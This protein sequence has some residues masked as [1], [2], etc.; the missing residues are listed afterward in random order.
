MVE[1]FDAPITKGVCFLHLPKRRT[2]LIQIIGR[3]LRLHKTKTIANMILPYSI[4]E[5]E[6]SI[7]YLSKFSKL[8]RTVLENSRHKAVSL[9][10]ELLAIE[11]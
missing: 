5:D 1:G 7:S 4:K 11:R 2:V 10:D 8:L 6:K 9:S 3:A